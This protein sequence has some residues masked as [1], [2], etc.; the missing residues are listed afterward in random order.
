MYAV[1]LAETSQHPHALGCELPD[2]APRAEICLSI[3]R[4]DEPSL[5]ESVAYSAGHFPSHGKGGRGCRGDDAGRVLGIRHTVRLGKLQRAEVC[6]GLVGCE[7]VLDLCEPD[8]VRGEWKT[9]HKGRE[10][11]LEI[12]CCLVS[13]V[14][15]LPRRYGGL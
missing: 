1:S 7:S 5:D 6:E 10:E 11:I 13:I 3:Q 4:F 14:C 12:L 9:D 2:R 8:S 15:L